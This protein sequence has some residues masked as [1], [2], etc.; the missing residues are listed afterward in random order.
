[1]E[2]KAKDRF[3]ACCKLAEYW[4]GRHDARREYEWKVAL[5][6]WAV[7]LAAV[8]YAGDIRGLWRGM[9]VPRRQ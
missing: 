4:S 6:F 2:T 9:A 5:G 1:M 8:H 7:I 3:D